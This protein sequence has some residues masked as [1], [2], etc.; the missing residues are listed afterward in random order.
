MRLILLLGFVLA[1]SLIAPVAMAVPALDCLIKASCDAAG[2]ETDVL[3][4]SDLFNAHAELPSQPNY[5]YKV[6][7]KAPPLTL[8]TDCASGGQSFLN[9]SAATD[10]HVEKSSAGNY[11]TGACISGAQIDCGYGADCSATGIP[12][13]PAVCLA[14][15][16]AD[17]NAHVANCTGSRQVQD[18][19][20]TIIPPQGMIS[21][22][23]FEEGS[24]TAIVDAMGGLNN[25]TFIKESTI[26]GWVNGKVGKAL[27]LG[28][29]AA[30]GWK[31]DYVRIKD[32]P[33]LRLSG[34]FTIEAWVYR[35]SLSAKPIVTKCDGDNCGNY[36]LN[37]Y[38]LYMNDNLKLWSEGGI[39]G[40]PKAAG[41]TN[42]PIGGWHHVA[43]TY[44]SSSKVVVFYLDGKTNGTTT[45][46]TIN[47]TYGN[48][49]LFLG[50]DGFY[51]FGG[52]LDEIA[53][54]NRALTDSEIFQHYNGGSGAD[55][56]TCD[57]QWV[58]Q[59][60]QPTYV[61]Q[62]AYDT[63]VCCWLGDNIAPTVNID[64][65]GPT[66]DHT[67]GRNDAG[68]NEPVTFTAT[69]VD[70][71]GGT[72]V[73]EIKLY[74]DGTLRNTCASS[75]CIWTKNDGYAAGQ[76]VSFYATA[77][78]FAG[79]LGRDPASGSKSFIVCSLGSVS[80]TPF[81][82]GTFGCQQGNKIQISVQ[83]S[84][85]TCPSP[86]YIQVDAAGGTCNV[87]AKLKPDGNGDM[88]GVNG[89]CTLGS[90]CTTNWILPAVPS[91]CEGQTVTATAASIRDKIDP[92]SWRLFGLITNPVGSFTIRGGLP[93]LIRVYASTEYVKH[94]DPVTIYSETSGGVGN[95]RLDCTSGGYG[96][97]SATAAS[98]PSCD[99]NSPWTTDGE[100]IVQCWVY[101]EGTGKFSD[102]NKTLLLESDN[103][104]PLVRWDKPELPAYVR[105]GASVTIT[106]GVTDPN[107]QVSPIVPGAGV[108][109]GVDCNISIDYK[110]TSFTNSVLYNSSTQSCNGTISLN[111]PSGLTDGNHTISMD[112]YDNVTNHVHVER[113]L[114]IDNTPP[115]A[116]IK[117]LPVWKNASSA[118]TVTFP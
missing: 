63:K 29:T 52:M 26:P 48:Y 106:A 117:G 57:G 10:A 62:S 27:N 20:G 50:Y 91:A 111:N 41:N 30:G 90:P 102:T 118:G 47:P 108:L 67:V 11:A 105:D 93:S 69:A 9:L 66:G 25:G 88:Q 43:V 36:F 8:G 33:S 64:Y 38:E 110:K 107:I 112:I 74:V 76:S 44:D 17:T 28:Y 42:V 99:F 35:D 32:S 83:Y 22:W 4:L 79:N 3:H 15:I 77:T 2:G 31:L 95:K 1:L 55:Y 18:K 115:Q 19:P 61:T 39:S 45:G 84:G 71:P 113:N 16:S 23:K 116:W 70:N 82:C 78:D 100:K 72:G 49:P 104:P 114:T 92:T 54:Y 13:G 24:G 58:G 46:V 73:S 37:G 68:V 21:Y 85:D 65:A 34:S 51:K 81:D 14:S 12:V 75:P 96:L 60:C 86:A 109:N 98:N 59:E 7:C 80:I 94:N 97:C 40:T 89:S 103:T 87:E 53:I 6:C 101:D 5:A 56:R